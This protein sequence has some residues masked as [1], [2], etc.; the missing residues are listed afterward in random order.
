MF[1]QPHEAV[2]V[3]VAMSSRVTGPHPGGQ[4]VDSLR[5][6]C[7]NRRWQYSKATSLR[8]SRGGSSRL[9]VE[10]TESTDRVEPSSSD[11]SSVKERDTLMPLCGRAGD[12]LWQPPRV[13]KVRNMRLCQLVPGAH[14]CLGC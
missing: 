8:R 14:I 1:K 4:P 10:A 6:L 5:L 11:L 2:Y 7:S 9:A 13:F 12:T 3:A